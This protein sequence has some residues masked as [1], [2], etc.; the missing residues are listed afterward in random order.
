MRI[1]DF[2]AKEAS[3]P[4][5]YQEHKFLVRNNSEQD[6][7]KRSNNKYMKIAFSLNS[8]NAPEPRKKTNMRK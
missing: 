3:T 1:Q 7:K 4:Y 5:H 6:P 2:S 8:Q